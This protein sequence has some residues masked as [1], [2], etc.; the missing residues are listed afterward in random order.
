VES[1][2]DGGGFDAASPVGVFG[3]EDAEVDERG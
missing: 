2:V 1:V 3:I